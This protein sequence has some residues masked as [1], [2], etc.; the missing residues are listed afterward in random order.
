[1]AELE[2]AGELRRRL[3]MVS[4][5]HAKVFLDVELRE[6]GKVQFAAGRRKAELEACGRGQHLARRPHGCPCG[7]MPPMELHDDEWT[8][9]YDLNAHAAEPPTTR[10]RLG[11]LVAQDWFNR[12]VLLAAVI[13]ELTARVDSMDA[14]LWELSR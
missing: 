9:N 2:S 11:A 4:P 14:Q 5:H 3:H 10:S 6:W 8:T 13:D 7:K 12:D 1:M